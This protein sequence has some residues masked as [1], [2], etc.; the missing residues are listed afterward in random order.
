M[1]TALNE[2]KLTYETKFLSAAIITT[3]W[4]KLIFNVYLH[5]FTKKQLLQKTTWYIEHHACDKEVFLKPCYSETVH[6]LCWC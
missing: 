1:K 2:V 6:L 4:P 5:L 3:I